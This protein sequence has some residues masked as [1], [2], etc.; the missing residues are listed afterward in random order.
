MG[1]MQLATTH[2]N[3]FT[4]MTRGERTAHF[5]LSVKV[6]PNGCWKWCGSNDGRYGTFWDGS[7]L[8]RAHRYSYRETLGPIPESLELLHSCDDGLC[9]CPYHL[10]P[11]TH[12]VN[13]KEASER[14]RFKNSA[15]GS[16]NPAAKLDEQ[17]VVDI[18]RRLSLGHSLRSIAKDYKVTHFIIGKIRD[19]QMW[20][21]VL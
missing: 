5:W 14:K 1:Q 18:R 12:A 11:D 3:Q 19:R 20:A 8:V 9:V 7:R 21:H 17:K 13:M 15:R 2:R 16:R 6:Q 4:K 10:R